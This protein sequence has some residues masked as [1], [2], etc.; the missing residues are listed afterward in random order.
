[1]SLHTSGQL[2]RVSF[3]GDWVLLLLF[4]TLTEPPKGQNWSLNHLSHLLLEHHCCS[5]LILILG[6]K[7]LG[8]LVLGL[9]LVDLSL[10]QFCLYRAPIESLKVRL[11]SAF[12]AQTPSGYSIY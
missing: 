11:L 4:H 5:F 10:S 9:Y 12:L 3:P 1:M 2:I 7:V 6:N 8:G